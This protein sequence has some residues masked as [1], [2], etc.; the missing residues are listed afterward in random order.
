M[1][2]IGRPHVAENAS[3]YLANPT[4]LG[5]WC[6]GKGSKPK[7]PPGQQKMPELSDYVKVGTC[8]DRASKILHRV[9]VIAEHSIRRRK[10]YDRFH[11]QQYRGGRERLYVEP[12]VVVGCFGRSYACT[13]HQS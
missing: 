6:T 5:R 3:A 11:A 2:Y 9:R 12:S 8:R 10:S 4:L 13:G 7:G 1:V